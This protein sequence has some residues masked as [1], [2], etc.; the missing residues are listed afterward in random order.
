VQQNAFA[1]AGIHQF[2]RQNVGRSRTRP[3]DP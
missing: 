3:L 2:D 1:G